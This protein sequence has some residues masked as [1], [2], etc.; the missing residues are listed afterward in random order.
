V[1]NLPITINHEVID[2]QVIA[3]DITTTLKTQKQLDEYHYRISDILESITD[4]FIAL[5]RDWRVT[6]WN[7]EAERLLRMPRKHIIGKKSGKH[8]MM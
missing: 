6:Y 3:G 1:T 7:K 5:N 8:T 4:G 2:N